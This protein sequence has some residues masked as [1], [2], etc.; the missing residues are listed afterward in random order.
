MNDNLKKWFNYLPPIFF[1]LIS[2]L[3]VLFFHPFFRTND[4]TSM[5]MK[6]EGLGDHLFKQNLDVVFQPVWMAKL[7]ALLPDYFGI[8]GYGHFIILGITIFVTLLFFNFKNGSNRFTWFIFAL[9]SIFIFLGNLQ[10][11]VT[12][13]IFFGIFYLIQQTKYQ[14]YISQILSYIFLIISFNIRWFFSLYLCLFY[15]FYLILFSYEKRKLILNAIVVIL[16]AGSSYAFQTY[17]QN[18]SLIGQGFTNTQDKRINLLD[19]GCA[20]YLQKNFEKL[21]LQNLS[22]NDIRLFRHWFQVDQDIRKNIRKDNNVVNCENNINF[23][24][25]ILT[26]FDWLKFLFT[27]ELIF[28]NLF[29]ILT[30][31]FLNNKKLFWFVSIV[32]LSYFV[33]GFFGR[34]PQFRIVISS[35]IVLSIMNLIKIKWNRSRLIIVSLIFFLVTYQSGYKRFSLYRWR[36]NNSAREYEVINRSIKEN[37]NSTLWWWAYG[38]NYLEWMY[39]IVKNDFNKNIKLYNLNH[40]WGDIDDPFFVKTPEI[41]KQGFTSKNGVNIIFY[42]YIYQERGEWFKIYCQEHY[43]KELK[44]KTYQHQNIPTN[45]SK[46]LV[47]NFSCS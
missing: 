26:G 21:R 14:G 5:L 30:I 42:D 8:Y 36:K 12:S 4:D 9:F 13:A 33:F 38:G 7:Y 25:R 40:D 3:L 22:I 23:Q 24:S 27:Q 6:I 28:L 46:I 10:F 44:I 1:A 45:I 18:K 15:F 39:P 34:P 17:S 47:A 31:F 43:G 35:L 32:Y 20:E 19:F 29:F 37:P 11:T 41:F 16:I 2:Y